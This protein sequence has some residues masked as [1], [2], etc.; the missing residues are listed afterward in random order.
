MNGS[1]HK[2]ISRLLVELGG[3]QL[4]LGWVVPLSPTWPRQCD[5]IGVC[6][7]HGEQS[8]SPGLIEVLDRDV[9]AGDQLWADQPM[10]WVGCC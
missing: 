4:N 5:P 7:L 3:R 6:E 8:G 1:S 9:H 2:P 10:P